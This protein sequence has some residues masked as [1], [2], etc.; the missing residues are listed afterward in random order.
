MTGCGVLEFERR[1]PWRDAAEARCLAAGELRPSP[2]AE[3]L[4]EIEGPNTCGLERPFRISALAEGQVRV[5]PAA[6]LGCPVHS[7]LN[8]WIAE[9]VQP[10][11]YANFGQPVTGLKNIASY[12]CRTRNNKKGAPLSEH[13][14]GNALDIKA[15]YLADG[16]EISVARGWR[17]MPDERAFLR[18]AQGGACGTFKTVLGPGSDGYHEDHFHLD[19]ARHDAA[20]QRAYCRP[21]PQSVPS[22]PQYQ[23]QQ[24]A[25]YPPGPSYP[26]D[27]PVYRD[28]DPYGYGTP[29][30]FAAEPRW[31][32]AR[33][34][35]PYARSLEDALDH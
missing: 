13:S 27:A 19:L 15:F 5:E 21:E 10:A 9:V 7:A 25:P 4:P 30:S 33:V 2:F 6:R 18:Q 26:P 22:A 1:E 34:P 31:P 29:M 24:E 35:T 12:G 17:G 32:I 3:A 14:F 16:R 11:A 23:P 28:Y 8:R 20:G